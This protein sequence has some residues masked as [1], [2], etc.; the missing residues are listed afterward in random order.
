MNG[1]VS[2]N[3]G[4]AQQKTSPNCYISQNFDNQINETFQG[5]LGHKMLSPNNQRKVLQ[6]D[7]QGNLNMGIEENNDYKQPLRF[8]PATGLAQQ[9]TFQGPFT[10]PQSFYRTENITS[11]N[12][13]EIM[14]RT[15]KPQAQNLPQITEHSNGQRLSALQRQNP[16]GHGKASSAK[17][18]RNSD[19]PLARILDK[20][21]G[22]TTNRIG[23]PQV[24]TNQINVQKIEGSPSRN[25]EGALSPNGKVTPGLVDFQTQVQTS[26]IESKGHTVNPNF[27]KSFSQTEKQGGNFLPTSSGA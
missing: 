8:D 24:V 19:D 5:P 17:H 7:R 10:Q 23:M 14:Q 6:F 4:L 3:K 18:T 27:K 22:Q 1:T 12:A 20:K 15:N 26:S 21:E 25:K 11:S 9:D 16:N 2:H 13:I